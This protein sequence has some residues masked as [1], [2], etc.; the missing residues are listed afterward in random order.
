MENEPHLVGIGRAA[1]R[2][3]ALELRFVQLDEVLRLAARAIQRVVDPLGRAALERGDDEADV[4]TEATRLD[5]RDDAALGG[6]PAF[7]GIACLGVTAQFDQS[8][9]GPIGGAGVALGGDDRVGMERA[10][11][12]QLPQ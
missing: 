5:A 7:G 4:E 10:V 3:I 12:R 8:A 2:S 6:A 1:R 9:Q 11:A